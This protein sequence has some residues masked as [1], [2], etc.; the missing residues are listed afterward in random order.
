[1][2]KD[3]VKGN[4]NEIKG[5]LKK[6]WGKLTNDDISEMKGT[7]EELLGNLEKRYGY[8]KEEAKQEVESFLE[9]LKSVKQG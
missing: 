3:I 7:Y 2:N 1:M 4:W 6:Q 8:E 9:K 5:K